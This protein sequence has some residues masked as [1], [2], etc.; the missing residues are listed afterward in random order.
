MTK[1][2]KQHLK[3]MSRSFWYGILVASTTW[4]FSLYLYWLL[5]KNSA[6]NRYGPLNW[7]HSPDDSGYIAVKHGDLSNGPNK[8]DYDK[9]EEQK[10]NLYIKYKK[11]KKFKKISQ[12]LI[13]ELR[14]VE[15]TAQGI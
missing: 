11:E 5:T 1:S 14:P 13:D 2:D 15:V 10:Q 4:C 3:T 12:H 7:S 8:I 6:E 9:D